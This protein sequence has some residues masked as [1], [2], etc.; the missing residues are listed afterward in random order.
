MKKIIALL[1]TVLMMFTLISCTN[2]NKETESLSVCL[3]SEPD[4]LD[5]ALN[6]S[7]DGS[8]MLAHLFSGLA[9]WS[10]NEAGESVIVPD[11]AQE[12]VK[13]TTNTDGTVSYIY[14]LKEG[15][16]WS[17]GKKLTADDFVF[18]WNRAASPELSGDYNYMFDVIVGYD[19]M[20]ATDD[21]GNYVNPDAKLAVKAVDATTLE[22]T[23]TNVVTYWNELLAFPVFYPVRSDVVADDS[24]ATSEATYISN[25]AYR[26]ISWEHNSV[27]T[28]TKNEDYYDA[29]NV[30]MPQLRFYLSDD[31]NN[32]LTNF[33]NGDW[34]LIDNVPSNELSSL[35]EEYGD[36]FA[37]TEQLG[38]YYI[39][40]NVNQDILPADSNLDQAQ[41]EKAKSEI[42][43]A[44][45]LLIDRNY[46]VS[47]ISKGNETPASTFIPKGLLD[48]DGTEFYK[49]SGKNADFIGYYN[50][51][52]SEEVFAENYDSAIKTLR[53]YYN[54]DEE[55]GKFTN[56]PTLTYIYNKNDN[57]QAIGEYIQ[58]ALAV[59]G[60]RV[61]LINQ[62]WNTFL[63]TRKQGD[64]TLARNGWLADYNY[65]LSFLDMWVSASGNNDIQFGKGDHEALAIYNLDLSSYGIDV[66]VK[67]GT[68][69]ETY[70]VLIN[71]IKTTNDADLRFE[72]MHMAEDMLME[73]GCILP[74]YYYTDVFMLDSKVNGF[75][76]NPLG[77]KY[78]MHCTIREDNQ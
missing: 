23:L 54:F 72:L 10:Q 43:K 46:I 77:Y 24:W 36:E 25:G 74:V 26:L 61:E 69:A 21:N 38:T 16:K 35:K 51:S 18:A 53:K 59:L 49:S 11:A 68:W 39:C 52:D 15:L 17:D 75:Y 66:T 8:T 14:K 48:P 28:M 58:G 5:P 47:S 41:A 40:W 30:T 70:D 37:I 27:I 32:M 63:N 44:I 56:V 22:V 78:F 4:T 65:P 19:E 57:H 55:S 12:L 50:V 64:Y 1:M 3:A 62:E 45:S 6:S 60:I 67:N 31:A 20:W 73:T 29:D 42:R 13:G 34:L 2:S 33:K 9:K 71:E 76:C 7:A